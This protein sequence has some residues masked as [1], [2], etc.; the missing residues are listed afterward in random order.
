VATGEQ[1]VRHPV[2]R[3]PG[4]VGLL[5]QGGVDALHQVGGHRAR[6]R[7]RRQEGVHP[8]GIIDMVLAAGPELGP[9]VA[10]DASLAAAV[11]AVGA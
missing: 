11:V 4:A 8:G 10:V 3:R 1:R 7:Q 6:L 5:A 2:V 9:L